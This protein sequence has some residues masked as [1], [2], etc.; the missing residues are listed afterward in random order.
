MEKNQKP[1][2]VFVQVVERPKRK[3]I[4]KRGVSATHYFEY[5]DEVGCEVWETLGRIKSAI[6]EPMG[7]WL[8]ESLQKA[9]TSEYVQGVEV[10][11]DFEGDVPSGFDIIGLPPCKMMVFQ[12]PPFDD[13]AFE[14]AP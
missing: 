12:G 10:D 11:A 4:L 6:H 13:D 5:C 8:P 2:V 7:L 1:P 14:S 9:G 3:L